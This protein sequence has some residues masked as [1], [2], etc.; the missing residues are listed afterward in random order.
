MKNIFTL[1]FISLILFSCSRDNEDEVIENNEPLITKMSLILYPNSFPYGNSELS[2]NFQYDNN[3]RLIKKTGGFLS[4]SGST[5]FDGYFTDKIYTTLVYDNNKVTVENFSSSPD[6]TVPKQSKYFVLDNNKQITQKDV[7]STMYSSYRD[8][9]QFFTYNT[10]GQL[11][12]I[13][14]TLPNMPYYP[15]DDYTETYLEKFYYDSKGNLTKSE[16]IFQKDGVN[17][18]EKTVRTFEDYDNSYNPWKRLYLLDEF[19]YRSISKNNFRKYTEV[20]YDYYG[21]ITST[22]VRDWGFNYDSSGNIIIN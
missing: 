13:K 20:K 11:T 16:Y 10:S 22:I 19:F 1:F 12:E 6:F 5:G 2:F 8:E 17:T 3:K 15:P 18:S 14:T 21:N 9:R 7:P 4:V